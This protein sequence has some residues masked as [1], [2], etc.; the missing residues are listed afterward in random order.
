MQANSYL[1]IGEARKEAAAWRKWVLQQEFKAELGL[2]V[3]HPRAGGAG[4]VGMKT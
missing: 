4:T 1:I 3:F 2:N